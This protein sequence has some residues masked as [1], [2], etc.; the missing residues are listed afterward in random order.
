MYSSLTTVLSSPCRKY[1]SEYQISR[2]WRVV[3]DTVFDVQI[4]GDG[5]DVEN[6]ELDLSKI[7]NI[8]EADEALSIS[9]HSRLAAPLNVNV[10]LAILLSN[11]DTITLCTS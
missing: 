11:N 4:K 5:S 7:P 9:P 3:V 10:N 8:Y 2:C 1:D 6:F